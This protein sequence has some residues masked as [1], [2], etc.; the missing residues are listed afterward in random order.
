M[1]SRK[2]ILVIGGSALLGIGL[3]T[4]INRAVAGRIKRTQPVRSNAAAAK[5][6]YFW[7][8]GRWILG[9]MSSVT[10]MQKGRVELPP[11]PPPPQEASPIGTTSPDGYWVMGAPRPGNG[12]QLTWRRTAS[13]VA[14]QRELTLQILVDRMRAEAIGTKID[15]DHG[16]RPGPDALRR[17]IAAAFA[18]ANPVPA[19]RLASYAWVDPKRPELEIVGWGGDITAIEPSP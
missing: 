4:A 19:A 1:N 13:S 10:P 5:I 11:V 15:P 2:L 9:E 14:A 18:A 6:G 8:R 7:H 16:L 17:E 12:N 3:G